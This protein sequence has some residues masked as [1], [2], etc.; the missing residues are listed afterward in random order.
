MP[1]SI[2]YK[3]GLV[4]CLAFYP[5]ICYDIY[6]L[7]QCPR[8]DSIESYIEL[9]SELSAFGGPI[10]AYFTLALNYTI[11][12]S[13]VAPNG[14][15]AFTRQGRVGDDE[16]NNFID[17]YFGLSEKQINTK[18]TG[19]IPPRAVVEMLL[20]SRLTGALHVFVCYYV[21]S[22]FVE[23]E[24][25]LHP[26]FPTD[27]L[28]LQ[29]FA[30]F[31]LNS[32]LCYLHLEHQW[33]VR[34]KK[35]QLSRLNAMM[36]LPRDENNELKE[37]ARLKI[38]RSSTVS[39]SSSKNNS[40]KSTSTK[41][42]LRTSSSD[43]RLPMPIHNPFD[44]KTLRGVELWFKVRQAVLQ[45]DQVST[46]V[47][48]LST[49][50]IFVVMAALLL[51]SFNLI[52]INRFQLSYFTIRSTLDIC[53]FGFIVYWQLHVATKVW[54]LE[55]EQL[56]LLKRAKF[57]LLSRPAKDTK[58]VV[59]LINLTIELCK[60]VPVPTMFGFTT[61]NFLNK[62]SGV[63]VLAFLNVLQTMWTQASSFGS[64]ALLISK[65]I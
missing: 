26:A 30:T 27:T 60:D 25:A 31:W 47:S 4:S 6:L 65:K 49:R 64:E 2:G 52:R 59:D 43:L 19:N 44:L 54:T 57:A 53:M 56:A 13:I 1:G 33:H 58:D 61:P 46:L 18:L 37:P 22:K 5:L 36:A 24:S 8:P 63:A 20:V 12:A 34:K 16:T 55:M 48:E 35:N 45:Q 3:V 11:Y 7:S 51:V 38:L 10:L 39:N 28:L 21:T 9:L 23:P 14:F 17:H 62:V 29:A 50:F 15:T 40:N 41:E 32:N 42:C